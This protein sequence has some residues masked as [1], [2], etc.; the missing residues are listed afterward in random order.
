MFF[1][2]ALFVIFGALGQ[3][4]KGGFLGL[5]LLVFSSTLLINVIFCSYLLSFV[6]A[7]TLFVCAEIGMNCPVFT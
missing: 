3:V 7:G 1:V 4:V 2:G 6:G 5:N